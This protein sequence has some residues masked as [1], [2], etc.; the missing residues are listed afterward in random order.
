MEEP[1]AFLKRMNKL[2]MKMTQARRKKDS[3]RLRKAVL[4][5]ITSVRL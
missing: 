4:R 3:R 5:E 1:A 2:S